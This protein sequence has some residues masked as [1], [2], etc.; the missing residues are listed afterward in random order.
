MI[1]GTFRY[2]L[3]KVS[4]EYYQSKFSAVGQGTKFRMRIRFN[5]PSEEDLVYAI[6]L[7]NNLFLGEMK[8]ISKRFHKHY[9]KYRW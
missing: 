9:F 6:N 7:C 8:P 3:S 1:S 5:S 4:S 2:T